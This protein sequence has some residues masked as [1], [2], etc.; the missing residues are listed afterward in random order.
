MKRLILGLAVLLLAAPGAQVAGLD[1]ILSSTKGDK[2]VLVVVCMNGCNWCEKQEKVLAKPAFS[3]CRHIQSKDKAVVKQ[4]GVKAF[5]TLILFNKG[6]EVRR[7]EGFLNA[8]QL[9]KFLR[10]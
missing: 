1:Q 5:P 9:K 6:K 4:F 10:Q 7:H 3:S 8:T 2:P